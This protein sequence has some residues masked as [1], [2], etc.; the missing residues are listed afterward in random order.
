LKAELK[1]LENGINYHERKITEFKKKH[2]RELPS[3]S[4]YNLQI[5]S[6]L[7][8]NL[9][10]ADMR[11]RL[12]EEKKVILEAQLM[13]TEPLTPIVVDG[14]KLALNP[15]ER[16]KGLRLELARMQSIYSEKHPDIK[17]LQREIGKLE[18][19]SRQSA[20]SVEKVKRINELEV[21]LASA[22]SEYGSAHPDVKAIQNE[23]DL[24]KKEIERLI[25]ETAKI[26]ISE[27][28]PDNPV[29]L[30]LTAQLKSIDLEI[31]AIKNDKQ[32]LTSKIQETRRAIE[33]FPILEEEQNVL[34]RDYENLKEKYAEISNK[35]MNS[36]IVKEMEGK[37][38]GGHFTLVSPAYLP[39]EPTKPN[40]LMI[41]ILSF[42]IAVGISSSL[43]VFKEKIDGSIRTAEQI[44]MLTGLPVLTSISYYKTKDEKKFDLFKRIGWLLILTVSVGAILYVVDQHLIKLSDLWMTFLDRIKLFA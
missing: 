7:E 15:N 9:D 11:L 42:F 41:V 13:N 37:K 31:K 24:L 40:R 3:D 38:K 8:R 43:A 19:A 4:G 5:L 14:E 6:R 27:E 16:L 39:I 23:I 2:I 21:K 33:K 28:K 32:E 30:N 20:D 18:A 10:T 35:L 34:N 12:L 26:K 1:R 44:K 25:S 29:Y 17:K 36:Q 22:T